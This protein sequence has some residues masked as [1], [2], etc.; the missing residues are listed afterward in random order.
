MAKVTWSE[1]ASDDLDVI[2]DMIARDSLLMA[3]LFAQQI[4]AATEP[5]A[6]FPLLGRAV[7]EKRR[8][9]LREVIV[10]SYRVIYRVRGDDVVILTIHHGARQLGPLS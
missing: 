7:P 8:E 1:Q 2:T 5:L 3:L 4:L 9:D 6:A 10:Q